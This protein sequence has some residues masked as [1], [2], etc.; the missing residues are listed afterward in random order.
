MPQHM[1]V[2]RCLTLVLG[3]LQR[4]GVFRV[5]A[6]KRVGGTSSIIASLQGG[7]ALL[8]RAGGN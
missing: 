8:E 2:G 3:Y 1:R 5:G 6:P 4:R 7:R